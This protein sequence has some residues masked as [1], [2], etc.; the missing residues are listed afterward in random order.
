MKKRNLYNLKSPEGYIKCQCGNTDH[1]DN[2]Y[3]LGWHELY[4]G[5]RN[6]W[7]C[8]DCIEKERDKW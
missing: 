5:N 1:K 8:Y 7:F 2:V 4:S 6:K 3:R